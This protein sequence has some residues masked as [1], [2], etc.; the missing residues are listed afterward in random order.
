MDL[1]QLRYFV[2]VVEAGS[3]TRAAAQLNVAQS[4]LSLHVR[5]MEERLGTGLLTRERTGVRPTAAG[6]RLLDHARIILGQVAL[7]EAELT[8]KTRAP[9]G[10]VSVGLP[11]GAA[12]LTAS[13]LLSVAESQLPNV[14]LKIVE[15]MTGSLEDWLSAGKLD[16]AILY[17]PT[18]RV[19]PHLELAREAFCLV[20]GPAC[21]LTGEEIELSE[22]P[23]FPLAVPM[24]ANSARRSIAEAAEQ[25]G[26][27]LDVRFEIDSLSSIIKMV[28]EGR[29]CSILT[30]A[31]IQNE[32]ALGLVRT[33]RIVNP[34]V[35]RSV[36]VAV[37]PGD[38]R[39]PA[40]AAAR[41]V[42]AGVVRMLVKRGD[43]PAF[44]PN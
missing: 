17:R 19:G 3:L 13:E 11:S 23:R 26:H 9:A 10:E 27:A 31:A 15:G 18:G 5:Q 34:T 1:R 21:T 42:L 16:L 6:E 29:V 20:V 33:L 14:S 22:I 2:A 7:A 40:V 4:A 8:C 25:F 36:V 28:S 43:W 30:P 38:R 41:E 32:V 24:S 37:N 12:R 44:L 35:T 39:A